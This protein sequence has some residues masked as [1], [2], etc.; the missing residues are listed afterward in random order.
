VASVHLR[1]SRTVLRFVLLFAMSLVPGTT[2]SQTV[3]TLSGMVQDSSG[4]VVPN[5]QV[6]LIR[7]GQVIVS[8]Y[9]DFEGHFSFHNLPIG[10]YDLW[11]QKSGFTEWRTSH[12]LVTNLGES[13][14]NV[15]LAIGGNGFVLPPPV[16]RRKFTAPIWNVWTENYEEDSPRFQP[17]RMQ[18]NHSYLLVVDL[19]ALS[20]AVYEHAVTYSRP[21]GSTLTDWLRNSSEEAAT[22]EVLAIPDSRYFQVL[23]ESERVRLLRIDLQKYRKTLENGFELGQSPFAYLAAN[24]GQAPFSFGR[25]AFQIQTKNIVGNGSVAFSFWLYDKP[26]DELTFSG[27]IAPESFACRNE[28]ALVENLK[29]VDLGAHQGYPDAAIHFLELDPDNL[30]GVFRCNVCGWKNDEFQTWD[31]GHGAS[32]FRQYFTRT[33]LKNIKYAALGPDYTNDP[34]QVSDAEY[35][36]QTFSNFCE[37]LYRLL[38]SSTD[39]SGAA[40]EASFRRF[41]AMQVAHPTQAVPDIFVRY[42]PANSDDAFIVPAGLARVPVGSGKSIFLGFHFRIESPL[43]LQRYTAS[44]TCLSRWVMLLPPPESQDV[45]LAKAR[46]EFSAVAKTFQGAPEDVTIFDNLE[47]FKQWLEPPAGAPRLE[48]AILILS[49]QADNTLFFD[50]SVSGIPSILEG[51]AFASP[52]LAVLDACDTADPNAYDWVEQFNSHGVDSVIASAIDV[53][54]RMGG[55]FLTLLANEFKSHTSDEK[56]TLGQATF[57]A[58]KALGNEDDANSQAY[59]PRALIFELLGNGNVRVCIPQ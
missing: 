27:C 1:N 58:V 34:A 48:D 32:W 46:D 7:N 24:E 8:T 12:I 11:V 55:E 36:P 20:Y 13:N 2:F 30:V 29:G 57:D 49:H 52:S 45:N 40:A 10:Y 43:Q 37:G 19:A 14:V 4:A 56:Y 31:L 53:D 15:K 42:L 51:R 25:V 17:A 9:T 28:P 26:I 50:E 6:R 41:V 59:G 21:A 18:P 3:A 35:S 38:F 44:P 33:I 47:R 39:G 54:P 16:S 23:S 5:A 22:L